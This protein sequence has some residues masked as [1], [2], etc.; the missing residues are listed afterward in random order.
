MKEG[1]ENLHYGLDT[2]RAMRPVS[3][4]RK[5]KTE[6][7]IGLIAEEINQLIPEVVKYDDDGNPSSMNYGRLVAV[8]VNAIQE[9]DAKW[10]SYNLA[11]HI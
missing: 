5:G 2:V 4:T 9:L 10:Q 8:L 11:L 1:V 3:Y 7:Q 6:T